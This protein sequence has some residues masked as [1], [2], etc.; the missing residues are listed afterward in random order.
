MKKNLTKYSE[1]VKRLVKKSTHPNRKDNF[2]KTTN[3]N[4]INKIFG[5]K[6]K[7]KNSSGKSK[8]TKIFFFRKPNQTDFLILNPERATVEARMTKIFHFSN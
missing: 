4:Q 8:P 5:G 7:G 2:Q 3:Q 1:P 6:N